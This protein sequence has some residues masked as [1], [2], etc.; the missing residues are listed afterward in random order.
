[1]T[2]QEWRSAMAALPRC[3]GGCKMEFHRYHVTGE[4]GAWDHAKDC[5]LGAGWAWVQPAVWF[6]VAIF[7]LWITYHLRDMNVPG[8]Y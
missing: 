6:V 2:W 4:D 5:P 3:R 1:M 8:C 7:V